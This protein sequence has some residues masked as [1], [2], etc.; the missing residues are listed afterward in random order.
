MWRGTLRVLVIGVACCGFA[1]ASTQALAAET[2]EKIKVA[3]DGKV[4]KEV[5]HLSIAAK[6]KV[7]WDADAG[8]TLKVLPEV[9]AAWPLDVA[10]TSNRCTGTLKPSPR[11]GRHP[12]RPQVD[13]T[14]GIDPVIIIDP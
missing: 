5:V 12:Y 13:K 9:A 8:M 3:A 6:D 1:M 10:C 2:T 11:L 4:D 14:T 7:Q